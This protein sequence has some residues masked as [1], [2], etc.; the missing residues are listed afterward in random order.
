[1]LADIARQEPRIGI[2]AAAD[3]IA[4]DHGNIA[5]LVEIRDIVGGR[6]AGKRDERGE[7]AG[8]FPQ[9]ACSTHSFPNGT[10]CNE[11]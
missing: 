9:D 6:R 2:V 8:R 1:M 5:A 11:E 4:D 7:D 3:A 10:G